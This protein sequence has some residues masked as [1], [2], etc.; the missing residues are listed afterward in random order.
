MSKQ[1]RFFSEDGTVNEDWIKESSMEDYLISHS[2][3]LFKRNRL[4]FL[5]YIH[6]LKIPIS[7]TGGGSL[8]N[9]SNCSAF[10][11]QALYNRLLKL[12]QHELEECEHSGN[13]IS[14]R[15]EKKI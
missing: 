9:L 4:Q 12:E 15:S 2:L 6:K 5:N 8:I 11:I 14:W 10:Q 3:R 13:L 7:E 1:L